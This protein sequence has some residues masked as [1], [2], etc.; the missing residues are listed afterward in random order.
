MS[1]TNKDTINK[2]DTDL[3]SNQDS[4][5]NDTNL[6]L[7]NKLISETDKQTKDKSKQINKNENKNKKLPNKNINKDLNI[8]SQDQTN[9]QNQINKPNNNNKIIQF[10]FK[11]P[12]PINNKPR[13][14]A[15]G[16]QTQAIHYEQMFDGF[17]SAGSPSTTRSEFHRYQNTERYLL[18]NRSPSNSTIALMAKQSNLDNIGP[19]STNLWNKQKDDLT[20]NYVHAKLRQL[21]TNNAND[22]NQQMV[23]YKSPPAAIP[24]AQLPRP[25]MNKTK[26]QN[27]NHY[28]FMNIITITFNAFIIIFKSIQIYIKWFTMRLSSI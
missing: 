3:T 17:N 26:V 24:K 9:N 7:I 20:A 15:I 21:D 8:I 19:H 18:N 11:D 2:A 6:D 1:D 27:I 25:I 5:I 13:V 10:S 28:I 23:I 12:K 22:S 14:P 4:D 16:P